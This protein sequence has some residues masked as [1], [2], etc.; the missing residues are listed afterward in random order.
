MTSPSQ[1]ETP[2]LEKYQPIA[3]LGHGG[4]GRVFQGR[5]AFPLSQERQCA[6]KIVRSERQGPK[7]LAMFAREALIGW[8]LT[9]HPNIINTRSFGQW[10]DGQLFVVL[11]EEGPA[12]AD[13][14]EHLHRQ[15]DRIRLFAAHM[16]RALGHL[17]SKEVVHCDIS[18]ANVLFG[19]DGN[20]K[21][22]DFGLAKKVKDIEIGN[23]LSGRVI[24]VRAYAAPELRIGG[25]PSYESDLYSLGVLL[26]ELVSEELPHRRGDLAKAHA[27]IQ[28][29]PPS[30]IPADL[31]ELI[32]GLTQPHPAHRLSWSEALAI[33]RRGSQ[34]IAS[35]E[36][37]A[38]IAT[39]WI[40]KERVRPP[41]PQRTKTDLF[42]AAVR[43]YE[44]WKAQARRIVEPSPPSEKQHPTLDRRR[45]W[46]LAAIVAVFLALLFVHHLTKP[47]GNQPAEQQPTNGT[48]SLELGEH[49][50][51]PN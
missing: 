47:A 2:I 33:L 12:L 15:Y 22:S 17:Q 43:H 14:F 6:I 5:I 9:G 48:Q 26:L 3:E 38:L 8:E 50:P 24:G 46:Q 42:T 18:Q 19:R 51:M 20:A 23:R 29:G 41:S 39:T 27:Q 32:E 45:P 11:D 7:A 10:P 37:L 34:P 1:R 13:I 49:S 36:D 35:E 4:M 31:A 44:H 21:L 40:D 25:R 28:K 30:G 16:L